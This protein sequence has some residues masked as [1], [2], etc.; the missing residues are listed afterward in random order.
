MFGEGGMAMLTFKRI[1][2]KNIVKV[3]GTEVVFDN[4]WDAWEFIYSVHSRRGRESV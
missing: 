1:R 3:D 4:L 2:G